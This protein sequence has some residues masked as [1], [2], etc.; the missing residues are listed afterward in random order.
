[1][2]IFAVRN[3]AFLKEGQNK[4]QQVNKRKFQKSTF[5]ISLIISTFYNSS[6]VTT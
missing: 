5:H 6:K 1:M 2:F 4:Q 3:I